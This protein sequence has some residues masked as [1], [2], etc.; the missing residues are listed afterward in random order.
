VLLT[1][2]VADA[3]RFAGG[4]LFDRVMAGWDVTVVTGDHGDARPLRILGARV[5][6]LECVLASPLRGPRPEVLSV[7]AELY[8][9]NVRI[10]HRMRD[11]LEDRMME[12][13]LWGDRWPSDLD[14]QVASMPHRLSMAARAFKAQ[15]LA[16]AAAPADPGGAT[17]TFRRG[18]LVRSLGNP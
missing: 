6:D 9:S 15:A 13:T 11:A 8:S 4:W 16:A 7:S 10:R 17:E 5:I 3:V 14:G 18:E 2:T 1:P 12:V